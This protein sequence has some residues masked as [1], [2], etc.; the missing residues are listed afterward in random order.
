MLTRFG[1]PASSINDVAEAVAFVDVHAAVL[2]VSR[3]AVRAHRSGDLVRQ[4]AE[5]RREGRPVRASS[6]L[7]GPP[8][9]RP[10]FRC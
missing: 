6:S 2:R 8:Q 4:R 1:S 10:V 7:R 9:A 5:L 3:R